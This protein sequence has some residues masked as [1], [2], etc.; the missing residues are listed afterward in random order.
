[1]E[2]EAKLITFEFENRTYVV[3]QEAYTNDLIRLPDGR[4]LIVLGWKE[5]V[6]PLP[7]KFEVLDPMMITRNIAIPQAQLVT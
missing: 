4:T 3:S 6:P 7:I 2:Q 5:I 1:M